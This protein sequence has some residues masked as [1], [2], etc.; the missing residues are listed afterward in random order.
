[1]LSKTAMRVLK[2]VAMH[3]GDSPLEIADSVGIHGAALNCVIAKLQRHGLID[4]E[5]CATDAGRAALA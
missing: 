1:M 3:G 5:W 4:D 2:F